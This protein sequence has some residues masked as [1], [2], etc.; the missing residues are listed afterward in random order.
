MRPAL[1]KPSTCWSLCSLRRTQLDSSQQI[2]RFL[3]L[4]LE[5]RRARAECEVPQTSYCLCGQNTRGLRQGSWNYS[6]RARPAHSTTPQW[7][8]PAH[9]PTP[10]SSHSTP[11]M[12]CKTESQNLNRKRWECGGGRGRM[13][14]ISGGQPDSTTRRGLQ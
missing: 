6:A 8:G 10:R 13:E 7:N 1:C 4:S 9:H 11:A 2:H 14:T 12:V 5:R 3:F